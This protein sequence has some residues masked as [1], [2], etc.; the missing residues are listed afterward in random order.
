MARPCSLSPAGHQASYG[1][2]A[3]VCCTGFVNFQVK[4][5]NHFQIE[6]CCLGLAQSKTSKQLLCYLSLR[7]TLATHLTRHTILAPLLN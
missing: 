2:S 7:S 3:V 6:I 5:K 4:S 1:V